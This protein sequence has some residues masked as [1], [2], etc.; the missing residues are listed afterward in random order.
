RALAARALRDHG[1]TVLEAGT[2]PDALAVGERHAGPVHLL[3]TDVVLP[4]L[5]GREVAERL[6]AV[7]PEVRV[8]YLSGYAADA[9]VRHGVR[10]AEVHFLH[11][12]FAPAALAHKVRK[13]L[14]AAGEPKG[15]PDSP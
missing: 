3:V 13:V 15:A 2:G 9:V 14:D 7:R 4:G 5:G 12:P 8:L 10:E 1:Y 6:A 11:K